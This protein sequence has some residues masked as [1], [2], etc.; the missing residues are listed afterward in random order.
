MCIRDSNKTE[1]EVI[2]EIEKIIEPCSYDGH[3]V[4]SKKEEKGE[5]VFFDISQI[6]KCV[7]LLLSRGYSV[8]KIANILSITERDVEILKVKENK[9]KQQSHKVLLKSF[10]EV[11]QEKIDVF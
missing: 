1:K 11:S 6:K 8:S 2:E 9:R 10:E 3:D 4:N 7:H 5:K